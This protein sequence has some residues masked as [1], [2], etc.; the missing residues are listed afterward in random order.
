MARRFMEEEYR[1]YFMNAKH[2]L[3][4]LLVILAIKWIR[5]NCFRVFVVVVVFAET[6]TYP[7]LQFYS[8]NANVI[9]FQT[10]L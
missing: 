5:S 10:I 6:R 2:V 8:K 3:K 9:K 1:M 7:L 4:A